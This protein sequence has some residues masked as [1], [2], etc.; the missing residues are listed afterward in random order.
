MTDRPPNAVLIGL[1]MVV[2]M[3]AAAIPVLANDNRNRA[4]TAVSQNRVFTVCDL[5]R[6]AQEMA[7]C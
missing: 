3:P 4:Q 6:R 5:A 1:S 7:A 2:D